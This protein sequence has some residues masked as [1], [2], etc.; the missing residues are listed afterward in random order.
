MVADWR[1]VESKILLTVCLGKAFL[2]HA[3]IVAYNGGKLG[4]QIK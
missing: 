1:R 4:V 2:E 3:V